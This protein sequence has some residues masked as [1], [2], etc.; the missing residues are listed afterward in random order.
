MTMIACCLLEQNCLS[1]A[2]CNELEHNFPTLCV[3][4]RRILSEVVQ[5]HSDEFTPF[6]GCT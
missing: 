2:E 1:V 5:N 6:L 3:F 4:E